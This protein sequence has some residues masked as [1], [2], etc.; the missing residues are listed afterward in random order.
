MQHNTTVF[1]VIDTSHFS[2]IRHY[3]TL[4]TGI[5]AAENVAFAA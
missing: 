5:M 3:V 4:K 2:M 1:K